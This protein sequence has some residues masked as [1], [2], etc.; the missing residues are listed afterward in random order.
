MV[1]S[2]YYAS[3]AIVEIHPDNTVTIESVSVTDGECL[4]SGA[5]DLSLSEV[6]K[7]KN[8]LSG[9]M[10]IPLGQ[11]AKVDKLTFNLEVV[12]LDAAS[13]L[14]DAKRA[15]DD[16]LIAYQTFKSENPNKRKN[17][18]S[19]EFYNWPAEIDFNASA[20]YLNSIGKM[21]APSGAPDKFMATLSAAKLVKHLIDMWHLDEQERN[22]RKYVEGEDAKITILPEAWLEELKRA[23]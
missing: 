16:A 8:V 5:W 23:L 21:S 11:K 12:F 6:E 2:N 22:N 4:L 17:L 15:A 19:P 7:I 3:I 13:F 1:G 20:M 14:S 18:V 10:I 9:K